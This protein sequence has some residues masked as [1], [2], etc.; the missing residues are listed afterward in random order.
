MREDASIPSLAPLYCGPYLVLEKC[1]K[2]FRLQLGSRTDVISVDRLKP[3]ISSDPVSVAVPPA[4]WRPIFHPTDPALCP[5]YLLAPSSA[6]AP[7]LTHTKKTVGFQLPL[8]AP[9]Q[10]NPPRTVRNRRTCSALTPPLHLGG[11]LWW[12][13]VRQSIPTVD[14]SLS[15]KS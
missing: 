10:R 2:Y 4:R 1:G 12:I 6:A 5:Q 11:V 13:D 14:T 7:V 15:P 3:V 8:P 9:V